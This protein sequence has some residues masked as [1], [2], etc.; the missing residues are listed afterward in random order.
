MVRGLHHIMHEEGVR[1]QCLKAEKAIVR[2]TVRVSLLSLPGK[3]KTQ[4]LFRSDH[5]ED[6]PINVLQQKKF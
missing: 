1:E 6:K 4:V 5:G 2:S 3:V